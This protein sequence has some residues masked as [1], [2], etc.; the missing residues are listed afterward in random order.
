MDEL[1]GRARLSVRERDDGAGL[2]AAFTGELDIA[3]LAEVTPQL[4]ELLARDPQPVCLDLAELDFLDSTGVT[5]LI[6]I[7][8]RFG[9]IE[10][11][12]A[13]EPVRRV[14]QVLG[15]AALLGLP[16]SRGHQDTPGVAGRPGRDGG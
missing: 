2:I 5:L 1:N 6:R 11:A 14:L 7:A 15:L 10:S 3:S 8:K 13:T 12:G 4:E 16:D 9:P